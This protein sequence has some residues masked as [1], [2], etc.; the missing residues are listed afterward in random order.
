MGRAAGTKGLPTPSPRKHNQR[1]HGG[2]VGGAGAAIR[3]R[4]IHLLPGQ[5][6][7]LCPDSCPL[8][9]GLSPV[10]THFTY[11]STEDSKDSFSPGQHGQRSCHIQGP[12]PEV[13]TSS[14]EGSVRIP[15]HSQRIRESP[16]QGPST[17][18]TARPSPTE[19]LPQ[20]SEL[21]VLE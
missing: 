6:L 12:S 3:W 16:C 17:H 19:H 2:R 1:G 7:Q 5:P 4:G 9:L 18:S 8:G 10:S 21:A 11:T 15:M 20:G 14:Q 13:N